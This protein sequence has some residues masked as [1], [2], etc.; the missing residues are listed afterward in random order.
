MLK[1]LYIS[2]IILC[3]LQL[4]QSKKTGL[5][6]IRIRAIGFYLTRM[7]PDG[8]SYVCE[9]G[10][11]SR[12]SEYARRSFMYT[13][14]YGFYL[15]DIGIFGNYINYG[16]FFVIGVIGLLWKVFKTQI[17]HS[18]NH[19]KY[20]FMV[21]LLTLSTGRGFSESE[22]I[23]VV[24]LALYLLDVSSYFIRNQPEITN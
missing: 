22:L 18:F 21:V 2:L 1:K 7:F 16:A 19:L 8:L 12:E 24:C 13:S 9:N 23:V 11:A 6:N 5:D 14:K 3:G 10:V 20:F 17:E 15:S 4:Y